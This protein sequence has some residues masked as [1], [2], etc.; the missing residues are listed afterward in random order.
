MTILGSTR[1]SSRCIDQRSWLK[2]PAAA[3]KLAMFGTTLARLD[4][5]L[6]VLNLAMNVRIRHYTVKR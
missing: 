1:A 5:A 4:D 2:S 3:F 6:A